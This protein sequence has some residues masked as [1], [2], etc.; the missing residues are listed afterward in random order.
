MRFFQVAKLDSAS[1]FFIGTFRFCA[2]VE[3]VETQ[4]ELK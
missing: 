1:S 2:I 4:L 3:V